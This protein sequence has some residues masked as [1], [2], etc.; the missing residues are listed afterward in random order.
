MLYRVNYQQR[1]S[2]VFNINIAGKEPSICLPGGFHHHNHCYSLH[3]FLSCLNCFVLRFGIEG[4]NTLG[5]VI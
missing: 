5:S 4:V 2:T 3:I 1:K